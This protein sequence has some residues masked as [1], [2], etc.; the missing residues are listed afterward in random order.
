MSVKTTTFGGVH[1]SG[2]DARK[3]LNQV[4]Y[5]R[6]KQAAKDACAHGLPMVKEF[7]EKGYSTINLASLKSNRKPDANQ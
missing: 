6:P 1:L 7:M 3:F 5:G 4:R 2:E